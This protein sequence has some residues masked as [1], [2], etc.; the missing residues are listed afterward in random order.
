[1]DL[2]GTWRA[3]EADDALRRLYPDPTFDDGTW[4]AIE[5]PGHWRSAP[6][7]AATD[8][9]LLFRRR[10]E[11]E[12]LDED[13]RA[14]LTFDGVFYQSDVWLDG[15]YVG[16]A[17]GYFAPHTFEVTEALRDRTGHTLAIEV[18]CSPQR[19]RKA[20]RNLTGVFQHWDCFDPDWNPGGIWRPVHLRTTGPLVITRL[21]VVCVEATSERAVLSCDATVDA[22][23]ADDAQLR[24]VIFGDNGVE[25][26]EPV[27]VSQGENRVEWNVTVEQP[28]L[29]WPHALGPTELVDVEVS[30][31]TSGGATSDRR[32]LRTGIRQVRMNDWVLSINGERLFVKGANQGPTRMALAEATAAELERDVVLAKEAGLD[33][34]RVHAHVSRP[35]L[36]AAADRHGMLVWQDLPLQWGYA[37]S[38]R[39]QAVKQARQ[40]VDLL[41]HHPS[42][43]IWCAHNEPIALDIEPGGEIDL[44]KAVRAGAAALVLPTYNKTILDGSLHRSLHKADRSRPVIPHSGVLGRT[45]THVYFGW[46]HGHERG[47]PRFASAWPRAV[48]FVSEFGAQAVPP[49]DDFLQAGDW[50]KLD[51]DRLSRTHALQRTFMARNGLDPDAFDT[52][53]DWRD[54]TQ[55]HQSTV[56][57]H[58]VETLRRLKYRPTGGFAM[59]SFADGWPAVSWSVLDHERHRKQAFYALAD[60]CRP[61]IVVADRPDETYEAGDAIALDVHVVSDLRERL[62]AVVVRAQLQ[63]TGGE[64]EWRWGGDVEPDSVARVGTIQAI[65]PDAPGPLTLTL[66]LDAPHAEVAATN[67]YAATV[68]RALS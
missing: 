2:T 27:R 50:P 60:A 16:D 32:E 22:A 52:F 13:Q 59:F 15:G 11:H 58:H 63:W 9:P 33:L 10:F 23:I 28:R 38:V 6:A 7:F 53:D 39:K 1:M 41:G 4:E 24:T 47:L 5:V 65:A 30:V 8:G 21:K 31:E 17:E 42:L 57:K 37:R 48:R 68:V 18:T 40:A 54:A 51:W 36:Y 26:I 14:W 12:R 25:H 43:A 49:T 44:G 46:Y 67:S 62:E 29:W 61:V 45:D 34:L 35:E 19:D 3:A 66:E 56:V 64:H 20:K 55:A